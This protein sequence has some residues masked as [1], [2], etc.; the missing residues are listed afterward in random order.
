M[1]HPHTSLLSRWAIALTALTALT[2]HATATAQ[3]RLEVFTFVNNQRRVLEVDA[4]VTGFGALRSIT[5]V[6]R[7][8]PALDPPLVSDIAVVAGGR[9]LAWGGSSLEAF[10]RRT[11]RVIDAGWLLPAGLGALTGIRLA[12]ADSHQPR[13][14]VQGDRWPGFELWTIDLRGAPAVR[15]GTSSLGIADAAYAAETDELFYL[16]AAVE[17]GGRITWIVGVNASTG[18][19]RRRWKRAGILSAIRT[20]PTGRVVWVDEAGISALDATTGATLASSNQFSAAKT[21]VDAARRLLLIRQGDFLVAVDPLRLTEIGRAR[22]A[23]IPPDPAVVRTAQTLSGRWMTGAYALRT[24]TRVT[25]LRSGRVAREDIVEKTCQALD[26]DAVGLDGRKR[27]TADLLSP[28]G[29]GGSAVGEREPTPNCRAVAVLVRSPFAPTE[30]ASSVNAGTVSLTWKDPGDTTEF[31]LE[32]GFAP[33]Q[34]AGAIRVGA[35]TSVTI[36]GVPPGAYYVR[37]K[38]LNEVGPSPASSDIR[39]VIP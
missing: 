17:N 6:D 4:T 5:S 35:V 27:A 8:P 3:E 7:L 36:P 11:R 13:L 14:F 25:L 31:E 9:F 23:F 18:Q 38:A 15:I 30:L 21:T 10:D 37:V 22:V 16:D 19:E 2:C 24:E 39:I 34:R 12:A 26:L 1:S 28:L 29:G 20:E 32:F 33:G